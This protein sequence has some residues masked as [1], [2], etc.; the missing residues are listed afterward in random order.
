MMRRSGQGLQRKKQY[1]PDFSE[2]IRSGKKKQMMIPGG[3][4]VTL[5]SMK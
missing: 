2:N 1:F 4:R 5:W 3:H